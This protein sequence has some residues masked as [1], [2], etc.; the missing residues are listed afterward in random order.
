[1]LDTASLISLKVADDTVTKVEVK[2]GY[3]DLAR[4][5]RGQPG[6]IEHGMDIKVQE[7]TG[8][9]QQVP[10]FQ[11][12]TDHGL[13]CLNNRPG[14]ENI[15]SPF[16]SDI[17]AGDEESGRTGQVYTSPSTYLMAVRPAHSTLKRE[18]RLHGEG[19]G[20]DTQFLKE[21]LTGY[22]KLE[23]QCQPHWKE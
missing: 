2:T 17:K 18:N 14:L 12:G 4:C 19:A 3:I 15:S 7:R 8:E 5:L 16:S 20:K 22:V 6:S 10:N 13:G 21:T 11:D 23:K 9:S 1:M